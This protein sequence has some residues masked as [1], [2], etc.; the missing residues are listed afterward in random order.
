MCIR[1]NVILP[2]S[3]KWE[4]NGEWFTFSL[5]RLSLTE[6]QTRKD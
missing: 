4:I 1:F 2:Q 6:D 5:Q 3:L